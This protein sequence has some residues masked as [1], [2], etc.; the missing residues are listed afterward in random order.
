MVGLPSAQLR[1]KYGEPTT[2]QP[3]EGGERWT[4]VSRGNARR[5]NPERVVFV[6]REPQPPPLP[7]RQRVFYE[8]Y[9]PYLYRDYEDRWVFLVGPDGVVREGS[10]HREWGYERKGY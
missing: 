8:P 6:V 9:A 4:Y 2:R 1:E 10:F 7:P 5:H 3:A